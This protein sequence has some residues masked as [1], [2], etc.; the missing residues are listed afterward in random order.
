MA[1]LADAEEFLKSIRKNHVSTLPFSIERKLTLLTHELEKKSRTWTTDDRHRAHSIASL[2]N[3]KLAHIRQWRV[4]EKLEDK[5]DPTYHDLANLYYALRE[6]QS[7]LGYYDAENS[8]YAEAVQALAKRRLKRPRVLLLG[9]STVYS[10]EN[11]AAMMHLEEMEGAEIVAFDLET[12]PLEEAQEY[13]GGELY[14]IKVTYMQGDATQ[15][16]LKPNSFDLAVT[17][18]F[19]T[20]IPHDQKPAVIR[21][22]KKLLKKRGMFVDNELM[23]PG[24]MPK[25]SFVA[26]FR[27]LAEQ[28]VHDGT[29]STRQRLGDLMVQFAKH[30]HFFPYEDIGQLRRDFAAEGFALDDRA[31]HAQPV[32]ARGETIVYSTMYALQAS[33][34]TAQATEL[35]AA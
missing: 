29:W 16:V 33:K 14:G 34:E 13:C 15:N 5:T 21:E 12:Q 25:D 24:T 31:I 35:D 3:E 6:G 1:T 7:T 10:L 26:F 30:D 22:T 17:H 23:I 32:Y 2:C 11:I 8:G 27:T 19:F 28:Y 20:H 18:L 9:F 4:F